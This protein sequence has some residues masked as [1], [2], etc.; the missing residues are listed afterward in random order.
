MELELAKKNNKNDCLL[1]LL[2]TED[3]RLNKSI[4]NFLECIVKVPVATVDEQKLLEIFEAVNDI[5]FR[6]AEF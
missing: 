2:V 4:I 3:L 6:S 1:T 5:S